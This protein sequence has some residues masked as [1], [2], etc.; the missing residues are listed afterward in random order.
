ME[1]PEALERLTAEVSRH[2]LV[3]IDTESDSFHHYRER[4]CLIQISTSE[5]DYIV[6]PL[7]LPDMSSLRPLCADPEREWIMNGADYDVVCLKRDF[8]IHFARLFD[9]VVAAQLLGYPATGLAALL[10]RH[11]GLQVSKSF[12][13]DEWFR[14]PLSAAQVSYALNDTRYLLRLRV[15]LREELQAAGRLEWAHEEFAALALREWTREPFTPQD[16]WKIHG[17]RDLT[18]RD[19]LV[20]RELAVARDRRARQTDRPPF[21]VISDSTLVEIARHAPRTLPAL[22]R[23]YGV[24]PLLVRRLGTDLLN[25]VQQG[26]ELDEK[27]LQPPPRGERRRHEPGVGARLEALKTWRRRKAEQLRMDPGVLT[28]VS[29]LQ[30]VARANP[31]T[32]EQALEIPGLSRWRAREFAAEWIEAMKGVR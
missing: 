19:Q 5:A 25:A 23:L 17:A 6:D 14:R 22:S 8:A 10:E 20:L 21:K 18:R 29:A 28:P 31:V 30:A 7:A 15:I 13:R 16:F 24:T 26:L 9:T 27:S 11:F 32:P 1:T 4:V 12:Q 2:A 3:G